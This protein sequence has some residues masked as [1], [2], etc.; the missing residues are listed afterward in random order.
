TEDDG[1]LEVDRNTGAC[2]HLTMKDGLLLNGIS[3]LHLQ[4]QTLFIGYQNAQ[5]GAVGTLDL[6]SHKFS[7]FTSN[8]PPGAGTNSQPFYRGPQ[9]NAFQPPQQ[10]VRWITE[11]ESGEMWFIVGLKGLQR[12]RCADNSWRD[13]W[14]PI[15]YTTNPAVNKSLAEKQSPKSIS[16]LQNP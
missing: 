5:N 16:L 15:I 3:S 1:L 6:A 12:F 13:F 11:A 10:P 4:G 2:R 8:L 14:S 7:S 9:V